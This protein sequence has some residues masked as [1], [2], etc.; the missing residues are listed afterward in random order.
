MTEETKQAL[1]LV[2][3]EEGYSEEHI[4]ELIEIGDKFFGDFV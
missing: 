2:G 3:A 4:Q 1:A